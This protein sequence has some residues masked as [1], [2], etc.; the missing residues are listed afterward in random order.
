M[1]AGKHWINYSS[2]LLLYTKICIHYTPHRMYVCG[3]VL[4]LLSVRCCK[5]RSYEFILLFI[6]I[7]NRCLLH[8]IKDWNCDGIFRRRPTL[9][10]NKISISQ[11]LLNRF[12]NVQVII[13]IEINHCTVTNVFTAMGACLLSRNITINYAYNF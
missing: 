2:N 13:S 7:I 1:N 11:H 12:D 10:Y 8:S 5:L 3:I 4:S 6:V 9:I